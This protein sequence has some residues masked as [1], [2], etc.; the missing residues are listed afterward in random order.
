MTIQHRI[1]S[2]AGLLGN[3]SDGYNG[4]TISLTVRQFYCDVQLQPSDKLEIQRGPEESNIFDSID[5][6]ATTIRL[7]GYYG[8]TRLIK[9]SV[10]RFFD[11]CGDQFDENKQNFRLSFS[12]TIPRQVGLAGSSAI[13]IAT[14]RC[15]SEYYHIDIPPHLF[16]SLALSVERDE[17]GIPAGLQDRVI[18]TMEGV[19]YMDFDHSK[20]KVENGLSFGEYQRLDSE[21]LPNLYVAYAES[22][23][24]PTEVLHNDL[25]QRFEAGDAQVKLAM[26]EFAQLA[27]QGKL[28]MEQKNH[29]QLSRLID[30][31]FDLRH[32]IC[33]ILPEH[34]RMVKVARSVG[35]SAKFCG[36]GG[37]IIGSFSDPAMFQTLQIEMGKI[38]CRTVCLEF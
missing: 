7:Q 24:E 29:E 15:L 20:M 33:R 14:L 23:G 2:R 19:V 17:L 10:K 4:K 26:H 16:A 35:V 21:L 9:A 18:Q 6:L 37:A 27:E 8:G 1:F 38:G 34:L 28:A 31:N 25:R 13:V 12:S 30:Q 32:S 5:R 11:F 22:V 36:S 3:P